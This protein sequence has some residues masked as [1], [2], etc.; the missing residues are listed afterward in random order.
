MHFTTTLAKCAFSVRLWL[1]VGVSLWVV[2]MPL[3]LDGCPATLT[4]PLQALANP[5]RFGMQGALAW[6]L[7]Q[8]AGG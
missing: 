1:A 7:A 8:A 5:L 4:Y 6:G 3:L 2:K